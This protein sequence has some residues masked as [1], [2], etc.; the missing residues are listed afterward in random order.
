[1]DSQIS[2][3]GRSLRLP[4]WARTGLR[5]AHF[6]APSLGNKLARTLYF[7]PTRLRAKAEEASVLARGA[8][9]TFGVEGREVVARAW[10]SGPAIL[11]V[12]GW[13]G[14]MGQLSPLV[15]PLV[16]RGHRVIA[17]DWPGHGESEGRSSSLAH[18][19]KVFP[20]LGGLVGPVHAVISHSFGA[21][22]TITALSQ[23]SLRPARAV[24]LAPAPRLKSYVERFSQAF[25][26]SSAMRAGFVAEAEAWL[27]ASFDE[28]EPLPRVHAL[29]C[30]A[31]I[32]H[33]ADDR[34]VDL[35]DAQA[36]QQAWRDSQLLQVE[37]LGHRR[38]LRDEAVIAAAVSFAGGGAGALSPAA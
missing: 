18:A 37:G 12:H 11:L 33:S 23:G 29:S 5:V 17:F 2:T 15:A 19:A 9:F 3:T 1:M 10:G 13:G 32:I 25:A 31:L 7:R 16:A 35:R 6:L 4:A 21:A 26:M 27:G 28:F 34:E 14:A 22:A 30:P 8:R 36:L 24:L 38:L 20:V